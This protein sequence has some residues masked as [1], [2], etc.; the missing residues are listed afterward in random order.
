MEMEH[1]QELERLMRQGIDS[2]LEGDVEEA[3]NCYQKL[4]Q[5]DPMWGELMMLSVYVAKKHDDKAY[6]SLA[7]LLA[8]ENKHHHTY[9]YAR[10]IFV[11]VEMRHE[12]Y[13]SAKSCID[14]MLKEGLSGLKVSRSAC[15][16]SLDEIEEAETF[17]REAISDGESG[18]Y[19]CLGD[20]LARKVQYKEA[21]EA[22]EKSPDHSTKV[23]GKMA[24]CLLPLHREKEALAIFR[25]LMREG[26]TSGLFMQG[27]CLDRL[28]YHRQAIDV[29]NILLTRNDM[30]AGMVEAMTGEIYERLHEYD[31][32]Y[33]MYEQQE[34]KVGLT[35]DIV[36]RKA[37]CLLEQEKTDE[38]LALLRKGRR[39]L[40]YEFHVDMG[41]AYLLMGDETRAL[42]HYLQELE[43]APE[44]A[45][46]VNYF[47]GQVYFKRGDLSKAQQ[48]FQDAWCSG[49][50]ESATYLAKICEAQNDNK[51]ALSWMERSKSHWASDSQCVCDYALLLQKNGRAQEAE[52]LLQKC[53]EAG[54]ESALLLLA[55]YYANCNKL[56]KAQKYYD[57]CI[58]KQVDGVNLSYCRYLLK[59]NDYTMALY[60]I[61]KDD[62]DDD[63]SNILPMIHDI[64]SKVGKV[65]LPE[66][67]IERLLLKL[68]R[69]VEAM[70]PDKRRRKKSSRK[71]KEEKNGRQEA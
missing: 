43:T 29:M 61:L 59:R 11:D 35:V 70:N 21:L 52:T 48:Y 28:G 68:K 57:Q 7:K 30:P 63:D 40:Q 32:A 18:G 20:V 22:Y 6:A 3:K 9:T 4:C 36:R 23:R 71:K 10:R 13:Q 12:H 5:Q 33:E 66:Y 24:C 60:Y 51:T 14:E 62:N 44:V 53:Y 26:E 65:S 8:E 27:V 1:H 2:H 58:E 56:D 54:E 45:P 55:E 42:R 16:L 46:I 64:L 38:A 15:C 67:L 47:V 17:A 39:K 49:Y 69:Y 25:Q 37:S 34:A 41:N 50:Y 19:E 31:K